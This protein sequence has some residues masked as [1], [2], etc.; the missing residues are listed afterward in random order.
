MTLS[1]SEFVHFSRGEFASLFCA[2][3]NFQ[4]L[5]P[6]YSLFFFA[7]ASPCLSNSLS[8]SGAL[9]ACHVNLGWTSARCVAVHTFETI[10]TTSTTPQPRLSHDEQMGAADQR[11]QGTGTELVIQGHHRNRLCGNRPSARGNSKRPLSLPCAH[12]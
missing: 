12:Q 9:R 3:Y 6:V 7:C 2:C 1:C 10:P 11:S 4:P 5:V 8:F